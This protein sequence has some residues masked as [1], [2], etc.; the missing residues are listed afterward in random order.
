MIEGAKGQLTVQRW[1]HPF[2]D[3]EWHRNGFF[4]V[5]NRDVTNCR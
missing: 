4:G 5:G 3:N 1:Q 2:A